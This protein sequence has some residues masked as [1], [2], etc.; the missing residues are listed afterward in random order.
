MASTYTWQFPEAA[1]ITGTVATPFKA[2][3]SPSPPRGMIRSTTPDCVANS[4]SSSWPPPAT[5][6]I[7]PSGNPADRHASIATE[8]RTAFECAAIEEPR[9]TIALPDFR[10]SAAASIVTFGTGLVD[11]RDHPERDPD[12]AHLEAVGQ[13]PPLDHL[14]DR[15]GQGRDVPHLTGD[16]RDAARI[17]RQPIHQRSGQ[18]GLAPGVEIPGVRLEDLGRA[19][20]QSRRDRLERCVPDRGRQRRQLRRGPL[21]QR[22]GLGY[23]CGSDGDAVGVAVM[24]MVSLTGYASTK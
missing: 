14:P 22:A 4:E 1:Y 12:L 16:D 18:P 6:A 17:Q 9:S 11:D 24:A 5:S 23:G 20:D 7:A 8:A 3:F 13:P 21:G 10:H 2:A 15:I 19:L